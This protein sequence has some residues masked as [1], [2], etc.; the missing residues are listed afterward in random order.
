MHQEFGHGL[1]RNFSLGSLIM[2]QWSYLR[3]WVR[4]RS[5]LKSWPGKDLIPSSLTW[6]LVGFISLGLW[7][8]GLQLLMTS[9]PETFL[10]S[11]PCESLK[12]FSLL[13]RNLKDRGRRNVL[14]R[15]KSQS[16]QTWLRR[17]N[18][19]TF[20]I[21]Y[22]L[23]ATRWIQPTFKA[24]GLHKRYEYKQWRSLR[25]M[26]K[27]VCHTTQVNQTPHFTDE[28][29]RLQVVSKRSCSQST[30]PSRTLVLFLLYTIKLSPL[31]LLQTSQTIHQL[32]TKEQKVVVE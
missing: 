12:E 3:W 10:S 4:L 29:Q 32:K 15:Q 30:S 28:A 9:W 11:L 22:W 2:L 1:P 13:H 23:W 5:H 21:F 7:Q 8:W 20:A 14:T 26:S 31:S 24:R 19:I 27:A 25:A 18:P 6:F 17:W 16:L